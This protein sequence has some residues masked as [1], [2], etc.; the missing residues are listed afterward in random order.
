MKKQKIT[1]ETV[2][3]AYQT[4]LRYKEAKEPLN[5]RILENEEWFHLRHSTGRSQNGPI[6]Q[7]SAWLFNSIVNKRRRHGQLPNPLR[8]TAGG[9]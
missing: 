3:A 9:K 6:T 1:P 5:R 7:S 2:K 4:L 8:F